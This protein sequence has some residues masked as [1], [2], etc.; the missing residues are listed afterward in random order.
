[1]SVVDMLAAWTG[2][3]WAGNV[4]KGCRCVDSV[5]IRRDLENFP[6]AG[7]CPTHLS[8]ALPAGRSLFHK[9]PKSL[10]SAG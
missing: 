8:R 6:R 2:N 5:S 1:M 7:R 4:P 3:L 10:I 9:P